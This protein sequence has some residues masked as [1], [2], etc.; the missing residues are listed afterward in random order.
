M[1]RQDYRW[2]WRSFFTS[3]SS[4]LYLFVY[5]LFYL[6]KL[7]FVRTVSSI[8]FVGYMLLASVFLSLATGVVGFLATY[9]FVH[10]MYGSVKVN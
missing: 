4:G 1:A 8:L 5:S 6:H 7:Q 3:G 2:W 9:V 10:K